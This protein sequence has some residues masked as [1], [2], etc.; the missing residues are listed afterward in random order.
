MA[1]WLP[2]LCTSRSLRLG[3]GQSSARGSTR[4]AKCCPSGRGHAGLAGC[5]RRAGESRDPAV[6]QKALTRALEANQIAGAGLDVLE[7]EPPDPD[8]P[9]VK[10]PN[11]ITFPHMGTATAETRYAMRKLA[12]ENVAAVVTG[13]MPEA[14]V[15]PIVLG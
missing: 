2:G 11:G 5:V 13:N 9:I 10:L 4:T 8:E 3:R 12:C 14:I 1:M 15:N 6:D 7:Q